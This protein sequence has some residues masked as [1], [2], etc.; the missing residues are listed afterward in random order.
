MESADESTPSSKENKDPA[1]TKNKPPDKKAHK[2]TNKSTTPGKEKPKKAEYDD[3]IND[4]EVFLQYSSTVDH[5]LEHN[6]RRTPSNKSAKESTEDEEI[7]FD[8]DEEKHGLLLGRSFIIEHFDDEQVL[9]LQQLIEEHGGRVVMR[10][11][12]KPADFVVLPMN[13]ECDSSLAKEMVKKK[14]F[15]LMTECTFQFFWG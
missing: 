6:N 14:D 8:N 2:T 1:N 4:D 15:F 10:K 7:T 3:G 11:D 9:H 12:N 13:T 5:Q